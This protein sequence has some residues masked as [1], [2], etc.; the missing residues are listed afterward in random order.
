MNDYAQ[1]QYFLYRK[2]HGSQRLVSLGNDVE[3][4]YD[5]EDV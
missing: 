4:N 5:V 2:L 3:K 1:D